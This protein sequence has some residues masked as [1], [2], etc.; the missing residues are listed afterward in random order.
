MFNTQPIP[1]GHEEKPHDAKPANGPARRVGL[2]IERSLLVCGALLLAIYGAVRLESF[3][4][5]RAALRAFNTLDSSASIAKRDD[6]S[7]PAP[8]EPTPAEQL[9]TPE[10]D[11]GLWGQRR[12]EAYKKISEVSS[13]V[14]MAIL[15][16]SK[17][18]LEV[19]LF[20]GTDDLTLN[21]AVGRIGGTARPGESGNIGIAGH[22]DGFFR[23]LKDVRVGD[24][25]ELKT[26]QGTDQYIV[27]RIQ[28]VR[29]QQV[30]VLRPRT[31]PSL[32]LV[33]CYP[34]YYIGSAP[35]RYIV[36]ALLS[37]GQTNPG[38]ETKSLGKTN[39]K[40]RIE[41]LTLNPSVNN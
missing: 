20:E 19:P 27:D 26:L 35:E 36:T 34:F 12:V 40:K 5:S 24:A 14:P 13:G 8:H 22:R 38:E 31:V 11:F 15:R 37:Q 41:N 4:A 6:G 7:A 1:G 16:I 2:W 3:L 23:G 21:H 9:T 30:E 28:I 29:P 18:H 17:I 33:T 25:I 32:T 39:S 10:A